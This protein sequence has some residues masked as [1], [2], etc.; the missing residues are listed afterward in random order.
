MLKSNT[1]NLYEL[2]DVF[3]NVVANLKNID[4]KIKPHVMVKYLNGEK[5]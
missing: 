1:L 3:N 5:V 4:I 2:Q